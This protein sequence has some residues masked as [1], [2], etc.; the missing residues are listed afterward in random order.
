MARIFAIIMLV[1]ATTYA[2]DSCVGWD[3]MV[4]DMLFAP[5]KDLIAKGS[6]YFQPIPD[7]DQHFGWGTHVK[8]SNGTV[9]NL[10]SFD[11]VHLSGRPSASYMCQNNDNITIAMDLTV[12]D[13]Q[14]HFDNFM[15]KIPALPE[16]GDTKATFKNSGE[17][18]YTT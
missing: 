6:A 3:D 11:I 1:I 10:T 12:N 14:F 15:A 17:F 8:I 7:L 13:L 2:D 16:I 18:S 4:E 5:A 9:G